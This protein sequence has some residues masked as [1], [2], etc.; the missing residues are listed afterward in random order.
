MSFNKLYS[1]VFFMVNSQCL[2]LAVQIST[3]NPLHFD[4]SLICGSQKTNSS[5]RLPTQSTSNS[6]FA[7]HLPFMLF[8]V[9]NSYL[10][11]SFPKHCFK[12]YLVH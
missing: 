10:S 4:A 7:S 12:L 11:V 3:N 2:T 1:Y 9:T 5:T 8:S 6:F